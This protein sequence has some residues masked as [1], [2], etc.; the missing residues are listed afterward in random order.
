MPSSLT[1]ISNAHQVGTISYNTNS[2]SVRP[3]YERLVWIALWECDVVRFALHYCTI[4]QSTRF[5]TLI[6]PRVMCARCVR[7]VR[8]AR[9]HGSSPR[10]LL[11]DILHR[12]CALF[13]FVLFSLSLLSCMYAY[14][15]CVLCPCRFRARLGEVSFLD[16]MVC[17]LQ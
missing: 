13:S 6:L 9:R 3:G 17:G 4:C 10:S 16:Y 7:H 5:G 8:A 1:N 15:L 11:H 12:V 14:D 2:Q